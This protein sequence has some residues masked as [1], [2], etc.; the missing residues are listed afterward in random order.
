MGKA[1]YL[2]KIRKPKKVEPTSLSPTTSVTVLHQRIIPRGNE[3]QNEAKESTR[4]KESHKGFKRIDNGERISLVACEKATE[5]ESTLATIYRDRSGKKIDIHEV[6]RRLVAKQV[7][8]EQSNWRDIQSCEQDVSTT[9]LLKQMIHRQ[10][11]QNL[12]LEDPMAD[13]TSPVRTELTLLEYKKGVNIPNRFGIKAG[14]FWDGVDR[15]NGFETLLLAK[16]TEFKYQ[17]KEMTQYSM[18]DEYDDI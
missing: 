5:R 18:N 3:N 16:R 8:N 10:R 11:Q 15:G 13:T 12:L 9:S 2:N 17:A 7:E 4:T 14:C 1:D 6:Q